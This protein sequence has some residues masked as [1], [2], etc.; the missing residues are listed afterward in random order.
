MQQRSLNIEVD[1][2]QYKIAV[3][4]CEYQ[5]ETRFQVSYKQ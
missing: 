1:N 3:I 5:G 2:I 4:P